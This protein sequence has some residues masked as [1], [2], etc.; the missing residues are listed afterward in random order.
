MNYVNDEWKEILD[1]NKLRS[2]DDIWQLEADWFEPPNKRRGGWS[3]VSKIPLVNDGKTQWVFL[4]RQEN[5]LS[6]SIRHPLGIPTFQKEIEN[7]KHFE[8][9]G[10]DSLVPVVFGTRKKRC[11]LITEG[12]V[13]YISFLS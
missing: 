5:H 3:G 6:H 12:L 2:F 7:I 9:A 4:K 11:I 13:N 8:R 10:I 1:R